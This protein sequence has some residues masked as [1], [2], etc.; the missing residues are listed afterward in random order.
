MF[1]A[2]EPRRLQPEVLNDVADPG[3]PV[4]RLHAIGKP[5][6]LEPESHSGKRIKRAE[7]P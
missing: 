6:T 4:E 5:R 2:T 1:I 7:M 3:Q